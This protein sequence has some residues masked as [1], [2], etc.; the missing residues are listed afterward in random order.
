MDFCYYCESDVNNFA[1]HIIR[2]HSH[3]TEVQQILSFDKQT[4][5]RRE[6]LA[7]LKKK[8][9]F[10]KNS[11]KC[12]KPMKQ[13]L[14]ANQTYLPCTKCLGFYRSK[15]LY[16]HR[17]KCDKDKSSKN[18]QAEGQSLLC[19][20]LRKIDPRLKE[21]VF[22]KMRPDKISLEAK[23]DF[24]I[25]A[26]GS[27]YLKTHREKHFISVTSRKMRELSRVLIE[28]KKIEPSTSNL[29]EAL[30]PK[31]YDT[32]VEATKIVA[33]YDVIEERFKSPTFA[34]NIATSL[35]QCCDIAIH[36]IVKNEPT[37]ETSNYEAQLK[38]MINLLESNW[39]FDISSRAGAD[40]SIKKFNKIT[41]VPLASDLKLLKNYLVSNAQKALQILEKKPKDLGAYNTLLETIFCRVILLNRR[42]PGE[43]QRMLLSTY[44]N[45]E[46]KSETYKE[47]EEVVSEAE[48]MLIQ[49]M[50]RV[51]I[52]GKRGRGVPV[53]FSL[54]VQNHIRHSLKVRT[55]FLAESNPYLF[56]KPGSNEP[57]C[58][59]KIMAKYSKACGAENPEALTCTRLRKHLATLTQLYNLSENEIEQLSTF[60]GHTPG[61]HRNSYRLP[62]DVYQTAKLSKLLLLMEKGIAG[63]YK[64]MT[65]DNINI[66]LEDN[67]LENENSDADIDDAEDE[68]EIVK[69]VIKE[70]NNSN[71]RVES[72]T[73]KSTCQIKVKSGKKRT[74]VPW[75]DEQKEIVTNYFATSIKKKQ[76]PKRVECEDLKSLYPQVLEN[77]D[78]LKIKVFIQNVYKKK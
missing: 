24:L 73:C 49:N 3:E 75:T 51:V 47:F 26:F 37:I 60:M 45:N 71:Q 22:P 63:E 15:F 17:K 57:L 4:K 36:M 18:A 58:G 2:N 5:G 34:M 25:C 35:K 16:R 28:F 14:Q 61:V 42:R 6:L 27:R 31:F 74:L 46:K 70:T 43:L 67:L 52:R 30:K 29:F 9:N 53:I 33:N 65:L 7:N 48:K 13:A 40:L 50:K 78:W 66:D 20:N 64:G 8:G 12:I 32:F 77:K 55:N 21:E 23:G 44:V 54:D 69:E 56:G 68:E 39:K 62:D 76:A 38:T 41:I 10:L 19:K 59:Y 1:R 11:E 72:E